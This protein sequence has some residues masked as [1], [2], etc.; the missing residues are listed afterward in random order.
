MNT[1]NDF[2]PQGYAVPVKSSNYMKLQPGENR[3][4]ILCSPI[5][6]W[7]WWEEGAEGSRRP[8]RIRLSDKIP[9]GVPME[10]D[11]RVRHFWAMVVYNYQEEQIQILE[12]T[13][14]TIQRTLKGLAAD[15]DWGNPKNYD[16]VINRVGEKLETKYEVL[17]KPARALD[18]GIVQAYEDMH[19]N[20]AALFDG[21]DPFAEVASAAGAK[22][23]DDA[24]KAGL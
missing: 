23:A 7:E 16:I 21:G 8:V 14:A 24:V 1:N 5:I 13:Q 6:G 18:K 22:L 10:G 2:L 4:R 3:L 9:A 17:P 15:A 11:N 12:V 20:L 19:I